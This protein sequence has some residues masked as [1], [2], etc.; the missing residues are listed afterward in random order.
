MKGAAR[1]ARRV[2]Q[3]FRQMRSAGGRPVRQYTAG[4]PITQLI[5]SI[6]S[7]NLPENRAREG[8]LRLQ[9]AAVDFN[10]L[11]VIPVGEMT[12]FVRDLPDARTKCEDLSRALNR[13]FAREHAVTL[14][15]LRDRPRREVD[16]YLN[17]L[18]GLEAY[19]RARIRLLGLG[20]HGIPLD[21]AMWAYAAARGIVDDSAS[22]DGALAFLERQIDPAEA[23]EFVSLL[24]RQAWAEFGPA[25]R[26]GEVRRIRSV[27]PDRTTRNMLQQVASAAAEARAAEL[28]ISRHR[29]EEAK[30]VARPT[31]RT[32]AR[33]AVR[34]PA[35]AKRAAAQVACSGRRSRAA[36]RKRG[37]APS[38]RDKTAKRVGRSARAKSA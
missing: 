27:P 5:L 30:P 28:T 10:D 18:D 26:R 16:A 38:V 22:L 15:Q 24:K 11:R 14:E 34:A 31:L 13:I 4:D 29:E 20:Q 35:V 9:A 21:E 23:L 25:V 3:L 12:E 17:A 33:V 8:L 37:T 6:F 36:A 19:S 2:K 1:C 7:R 32:R